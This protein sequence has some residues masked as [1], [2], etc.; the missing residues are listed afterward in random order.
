MYI[1]ILI[2]RKTYL[3]TVT[4]LLTAGI[5]VVEFIGLLSKMYSYMKDNEKG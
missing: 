2:R 5:P 3:T 4:T 1:M